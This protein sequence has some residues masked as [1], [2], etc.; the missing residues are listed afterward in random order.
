M[1]SPLVSILVPCKSADR[2]T[3]ECLS[4]YAKL[5]YEP[6][7]IVLLPDAPCAVE[8][9]KVV[10]TGSVTPG[11]K[12]NIG[13]SVAKGKI[14]AYVDA[15]AYPREDWLTNAIGHLMED[16]VGAV[17][18][19][20]LT[21][22]DGNNFSLGQDVI[23]SSFLMGG[24]AS[25]YKRTKELST[26][27]IHSVNFVA[28]RRVIEAAGGW[29]EKYWPGE[30]TLISLR[31]KELDYKQVFAPDVVVYHHRRT[32]WSGYLRQIWNYGKHRGFFAKRFPGNS[33][34]A[35][36]V[37]RAQWIILTLLEEEE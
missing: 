33:R 34:S 20:G 36:R 37:P 2:L 19:P 5:E 8:G 21:P 32:T 11:R 13:A 28:W 14:F 15:D 4:H 29:N 27:D 35:S 23:L 9:T 31:L 10:P 17:G 24:L 18:G 22:P 1:N 25:R 6:F 16:G 7:E 12:R 30:D 26:D 3:R